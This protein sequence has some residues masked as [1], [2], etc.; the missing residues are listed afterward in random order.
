MSGFSRTL[1]VILLVIIAP[2]LPAGEGSDQPTAADHVTYLASPALKGRKPLSCG[3]KKARVYIAEHFEELGLVPWG[4]EENYFQSVVIGTNV[5][6][7]LPGSDTLPIHPFGLSD[8]M[9]AVEP[10][11]WQ[12]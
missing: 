1:L 5:V 8:I 10:S 3:S 7:V 6:G 11:Q 2:R 9:V 12:D 4:T